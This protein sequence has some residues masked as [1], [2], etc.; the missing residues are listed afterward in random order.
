MQITEEEVEEDVDPEEEEEEEAED[1]EDEDETEDEAEDGG[2]TLT[3]LLQSQY[4]G[5][6]LGDTALGVVGLR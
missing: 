2:D 1:E 4:S 5:C 3:V 6:R